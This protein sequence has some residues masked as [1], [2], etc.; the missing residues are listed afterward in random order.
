MPYVTATLLLGLALIPACSL[1]PE[2]PPPGCRPDHPADCDD[3]WSC[4]AGVCV[5]P[6]T[7]L[8]PPT[9]G[10]MQQ[11]AQEDADDLDD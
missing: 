3:G 4:R 11:D 8:S 7:P 5:R 1:Q 9:D 10:S 6:T 2:S